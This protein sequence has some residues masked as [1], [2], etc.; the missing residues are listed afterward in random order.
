[1]RVPVDRMDWNDL[2]DSLVR[3][4]VRGA[5]PEQKRL[6]EYFGADEYAEL[7][8]LAA[9]AQ[10][11]RSRSQRR[12]TIVLLPGIMGSSLASVEGRDEDA[13]WINLP[14]I[15]LGALSRLKLSPD[16]KTEVKKGL[17]VYPTGVD[18]RTYARAVL[19]LRAHWEVE[20]F[21]YDWRKD[22][23]VAADALAGL[24]RSRFAGRPVHLLAHSMGGLAS[25]NFILRHRKLWESMQDKTGAGGRLVMLGTPN[26]GSFAI[27]QVF[28]GAETM[29]RWLERLDFKNN[30]R[31]VLDIVNSFVGSYQMLPAPSK[32]PGLE[33]VLYQVRSWGNEVPVSPLHLDRAARF[34]R[35]LAAGDTIDPE[36]MIYV[37][38]SGR[39]TICDLRFVAPGEFEYSTTLLGDGRVPHDLGL[40]EGVPT[41]YV[42]ESHGSLPR[43]DQVLAAVE[44]LLVT[45]RSTVLSARPPAA[46]ALAA[47]GAVWRR[48]IADHAAGNELQAIAERAQRGQATPEEIRAVEEA[49]QAAALG[50]DRPANAWAA[51][52]TETGTAAAAK[53]TNA[54]AAARRRPTGGS[55]S[56]LLVEIVCGDI[57]RATAPIVVVGHYQGSPPRSAEGAIDRAF[58]FWISRAEEH[59]M[60]GA[61]LGEL[62]FIPVR[63]RELAAGA[64]LLAGMGEPG[65]FGREDLRYLVKNVALAVSALGH[66]SLATVLIGSG[67]GSLPKSQAIRGLLLGLGDA[68]PLLPREARLRRLQLVASSEATCAE[69][70][71]RL[72]AD[73][74][75]HPYTDLDVRLTPRLRKVGGPA[76]PAE[77]PEDLEKEECGPR[78]TVERTGD[79]FRYSAMTTDAVIPVREVQVQ[80]FFA[81]GIAERL[82]HSETREEQ[83]KY[84]TLLHSYLL[85]EDFQRI[86]A[87]A[88]GPVTLILDRSTAGLPWEMACFPGAGGLAAL[89][90]HRQL[91]RQFRTLLSTPPGSSPQVNRA[92]KALVIADP[93][94]E[95]ELQLPGARREGREVVRVLDEF[96]TGSGLQIEII[97]RIG[98]VECDPVEIL[99]LILNGEFDLVHFAGHGVFDSSDPAK[100]GWVFGRELVLSAREIFRARRVPRL[101][102]A[103]ACFSGVIRDGQPFLADEM[104]R[105]LAGLAEAFFER[106]IQNYL[107]AGWPVGDQPAVAFAREFYGRVLRGGT[108]GEAIGQARQ[109]ILAE[110]S[111]WGAYQHYGAPGARLVASAAPA[112]KAGRRPVAKPSAESKPEKKPAAKRPHA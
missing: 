59:G 96:R 98:A 6:R 5:T 92:L 64:A 110:G 17:A 56:R 85:P 49:I 67:S 33:P 89:G 29:V 31:E 104:N 103:N 9:D 10:R 48:S 51:L 111:T 63:R 65:K 75:D 32:R 44:E 40:L 55:Q 50:R 71:E 86:I 73:L 77:R 27:P 66:Q 37:A 36:R 52:Q 61:G 81:D 69:I 90:P 11:T 16:G 43:N 30:L 53:R 62:F 8:Q 3:S 87:D 38:G 7:E 14:R 45:G 78:I 88:D 42:D 19:K 106:G 68:A 105:G 13:I 15:V 28:T 76:E 47:E 57:T 99:A 54:T 108:L 93:A 84:G 72:E 97:D 41:Y 21:P 23:D 25:R 60:I 20:A 79:V 70:R 1:M 34:H 112:G 2:E 91:T 95:A 94:R 26:Y 80:S 4:A 107:G 39:E 102:F 22:L 35:D 74:S 83:A 82:M 101:V 100:S 109:V 18:K 24:V 12:G 58:K 46:R